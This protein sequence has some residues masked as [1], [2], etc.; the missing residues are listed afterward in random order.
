MVLLGDWPT[1]ERL[2]RQELA[3]GPDHD[4]P[5]RSIGYLDHGIA[6]AHLGRLDE[7]A[8]AGMRAL[9]SRRVVGSVLV[10]AGKLDQALV[11]ADADVAEVR[12]FHERYLEARRAH[13]RKP[14][15]ITAN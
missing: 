5:G 15:A 14:K 13:Q 9:S 7:A 1:A 3:S 10:Q 8:A 6:L 12:T 4:T 11:E 2:K